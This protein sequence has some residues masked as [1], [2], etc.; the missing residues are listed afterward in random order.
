MTFKT[1]IVAVI[2]SL[3]S[4]TT[5]SAEPVDVLY[6]GKVTLSKPDK[7]DRQ[8]KKDIAAVALKIKKLKRKG[9]VKLIGDVPSA[10]TQEEYIAKAVFLARTVEAY[11][12]TLLAASHQSYITAAKYGGEKRQGPNS[13]A[14]LFYPHELKVQGAGFIS[15]KVTY[16]DLPK[17]ADPVESPTVTVD[18][19]DT[20][21]KPVESTVNQ[22]NIEGGLLS[23]AP[24]DD[25]PVEV[26]SKKEQGRALSEDA[27]LAND[28]VIRAKARAAE[29][30]KRLEREQ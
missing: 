3:I 14:I 26:A 18:T 6:S 13:V 30:A 25:E 28:L 22:P 11:L 29:K 1:L 12:K 19:A 2:A 15:S 27:N 4:Y 10:E 23:P 8:A 5:A 16:E 20:V 24:P 17:V 9:T 7:L 21:E